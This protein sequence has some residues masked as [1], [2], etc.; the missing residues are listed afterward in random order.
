MIVFS[1]FFNKLVNKAETNIFAKENFDKPSRLNGQHLATSATCFSSN[2]FGT[3]VRV[4]EESPR[5]R[6][7]R[8]SFHWRWFRWWSTAKKCFQNRPRDRA[9]A[10]GSSRVR[11]L[12]NL[13]PSFPLGHPGGFYR[14]PTPS[15]PTPALNRDLRIG[16]DRIAPTKRDSRSCAPLLTCTFLSQDWSQGEDD[17][18]YYLLLYGNCWN[19]WMISLLLEGVNFFKT[20]DKI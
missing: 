15:P 14:D 6:L 7:D 18:N 20:N 10:Y 16:E 13:S 1:F 12:P 3:I 19:C 5:G 2:I 17:R 9:T 11:A 8:W 4:R